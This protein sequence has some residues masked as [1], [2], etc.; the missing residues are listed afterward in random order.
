MVSKPS[1]L[2]NFQQALLAVI[3]GNVVYFALV[4]SLPMIARHR[5]SRLDL[6]MLID[7][8]FCLAVYA[9]IRTIRRWR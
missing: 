5:P 9:F 6:G 2:V 7:F 4:P 8:C 1:V 3:L